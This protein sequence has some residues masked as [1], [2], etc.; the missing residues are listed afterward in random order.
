MSTAF[1][2]LVDG[3]AS[4]LQ[5]AH[6]ALVVHRNRVRAIERAEA[7]GLAVRL[8]SS[9]REVDAPLGAQDWLTTLEVEAFARGTTGQD[10]ATTVDALL[11]TAWV[12]VLGAPLALPGVTDVDSDPALDW[13]FAAA[14]TPLASAT[15]RLQVRH[16]TQANSLAAWSF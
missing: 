12:A 6:P 9:R 16:R 4:A 3:I 2:G 15:F 7:S 13:D 1:A 14:D 8:V 10:P 11:G 5:A